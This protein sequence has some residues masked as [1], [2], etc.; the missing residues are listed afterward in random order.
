MRNWHTEGK[1]CKG[2]TNDNTVS[3]QSSEL[4]KPADQPLVGDQSAAD[5]IPD[6]QQSVEDES[7]SIQAAEE[8]TGG[9]LTSKG[10]HLCVKPGSSG[11]TV[12]IVTGFYVTKRQLSLLQVIF[13]GF[14]L[15]I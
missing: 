14:N 10:R 9:E 7:N 8:I 3:V 6:A 1:N 2:Q 12:K 5:Q 15:E 4:T 11:L 13:Y